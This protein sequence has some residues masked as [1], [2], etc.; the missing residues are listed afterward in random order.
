MVTVQHLILSVT[1][2]LWRILISQIYPLTED[3]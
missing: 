1:F 3:R 2:I